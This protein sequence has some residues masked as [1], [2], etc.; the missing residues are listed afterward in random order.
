MDESIYFGGVPLSRLREWLGE[1]V[2][3]PD[4]V[5]DTLSVRIT[6]VID[7]V[8]HE[9]EVPAKAVAWD[10]LGFEKTFRSI[11]DI[12][13]RASEPAYEIVLQALSAAS[14]LHLLTQCRA[15]RIG[16]DRWIIHTQCVKHLSER[17]G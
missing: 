1:P 14:Q 7:D 10:C 13:S 12:A 17:L 2:E 16:D 3:S 6:H 5:V 11:H 9:Q 15:E 4:D 8:T